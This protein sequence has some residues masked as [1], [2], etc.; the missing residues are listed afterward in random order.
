MSIKEKYPDSNLEHFIA[1]FNDSPNKQN[2]SNHVSLAFTMEGKEYLEVLLTEVNTVLLK[3]DQKLFVDRA[4]ESNIPS[5]LEEHLSI[6][7]EETNTF[8]M[9]N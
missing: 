3:G 1:M 2:L 9:N 4:I 5:F 8:L 7:K 6:I